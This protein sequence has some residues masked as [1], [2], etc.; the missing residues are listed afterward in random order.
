MCAQ[1]VAT[2][3]TFAQTHVLRPTAALNPPPTLQALE[4]ALHA[5]WA[6]AIWAGQGDTGSRRPIPTQPPFTYRDGADGYHF[7][8]KMINPVSDEPRSAVRPC[9]WRLVGFSLCRNCPW[10]KL[11]VPAQKSMSSLSP[12]TSLISCLR[13]HLFTFCQQKAMPRPSLQDVNSNL[14]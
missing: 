1:T 5:L 4:Q 13:M 6:D 7:S 8:V 14:L 2:W 12:L 9:G 3:P 10:S 11:R